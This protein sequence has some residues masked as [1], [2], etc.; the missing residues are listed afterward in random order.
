M[1]HHTPEPLR[2][3]C[4]QS[5]S[6]INQQD[7]WSR[8]ESPLN[9]PVSEKE[10]LPGPV[11]QPEPAAPSKA[12]P[13]SPQ[14]P[15]VQEGHRQG[16]EENRS[17]EAS[18]HPNSQRSIRIKMKVTDSNNEQLHPSNCYFV[19]CPLKLDPDLM[20]EANGSPA[21]GPGRDEPVRMFR[22]G[23]VRCYNKRKSH[24][25]ADMSRI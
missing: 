24:K 13:G 11:P 10:K 5:A 20:Q 3:F 7:V 18:P 21:V 25:I 12:S 1:L 22:A 16:D 19:L 6:I 23:S 8:A 9:E 15:S 2:D 17:E 14:C 4:A